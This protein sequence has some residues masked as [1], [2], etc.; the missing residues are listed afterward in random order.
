MTEVLVRAR[1]Y[2][3][4]Q[5]PRQYLPQESRVYADITELYESGD[6]AY[7]DSIQRAAV[8]IGLMPIV[9]LYPFMQRFFVKGVLIG[10]IKE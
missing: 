10:S 1:H 8:I 2:V 4:I 6:N 3:G 9:L 7:V 5:D